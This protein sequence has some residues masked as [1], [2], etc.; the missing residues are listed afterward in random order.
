MK[1]NSKLNLKQAVILVWIYKIYHLWT[2]EEYFNS[3]NEFDLPTWMIYTVV[4]LCPRSFYIQCITL[5]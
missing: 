5:Q 4:F 3:L 2:E 1:L